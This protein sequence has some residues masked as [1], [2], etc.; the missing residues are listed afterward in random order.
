MAMALELHREFPD[1]MQAPSAEREGRRRLLWTCYVMDRFTATGS[2]RP[3]LIADESILLRL[4]AWPYDVSNV[5]QEGAL[6]STGNIVRH[7]T[8]GVGSDSPSASLIGIV[9][10]LG[11]ANRY[12][13]SSQNRSDSHVPWQTQSELSVIRGELQ[14]WANEHPQMFSGVDHLL[15]QIESPTIILSRLVFHVIHCLLYRPFLPLDLMELTGPEHH[16]SWQM[17]ATN[18]AFFHA[19]TIN[20]LLDHATRIST[21][22]WTSFVGYCLCTAGTIHIHGALYTPREGSDNFSKSIDYLTQTMNQ[23]DEIKA[24]HAGCFHAGETLQRVCAAHSHLVKSI[25]A[26]GRYSPILHFD[27]FFDRYPG[28]IVDAGHVVLSDVAMDH[29]P[30]E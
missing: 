18:M 20:D 2:K 12:L 30:D 27:N 6:F 22:E 1:G 28:L 10:V 16:K 19:S 8:G 23:L 21:Q 29:P 15:S 14:I 24:Y 17:E 26:S 11:L 5:Y 25:A 9:R 13:G 3:S 7:E 4:P